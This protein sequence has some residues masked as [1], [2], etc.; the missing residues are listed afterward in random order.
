M[1]ILCYKDHQENF[2]GRYN[3]SNGFYSISR[4]EGRACPRALD[5]HCR[6]P[7]A[8]PE[9]TPGGGNGGRELWGGVRVR[10]RVT[11][12][13]AGGGVRVRVR[14]QVVQDLGRVLSSVGSSG[15]AFDSRFRSGFGAE[16]HG[17][18]FVR[19]RARV[20]VA[21]R[22]GGFGFGFGFR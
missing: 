16:G 6:N 5:P 9:C 18:G 17:F 7:S 8:V 1:G 4:H 3:S 13:S 22:G 11:G 21:A 2:A 19:F 10:V 12:L 15:S 20:Q 14:V